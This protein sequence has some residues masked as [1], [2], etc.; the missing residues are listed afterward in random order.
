MPPLP[1]QQVDRQRTPHSWADLVPVVKEWWRTHTGEPLSLGAERGLHSQWA[2]ETGDGRFE[3]N[4]NAGN[5]RRGSK[6]MGEG[7]DGDFTELFDKSG[8]SLGMFRSYETAGNGVVNWLSLLNQAPA[9]AAAMKALR[10]GNAFGF[11]DNIGAYDR[12]NPLYVPGLYAKYKALFSG[13]IV[14][15]PAP[16]LETWASI[17]VLTTAGIALATLWVVTRKQPSATVAA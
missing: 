1:G 4:E 3:W 8:K 14:P 7:W 9:F 6:F 2:V 16:K 15:E 10:D 11:F 5:L 12:G 17:A 13:A